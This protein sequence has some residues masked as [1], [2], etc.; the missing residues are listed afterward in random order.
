MRCPGRTVIAEEVEMKAISPLQFWAGLLVWPFDGYSDNCRICRE[1]ADSG[2]VAR[3]R[4]GFCAGLRRRKTASVSGKG[5]DLLGQ[6]F[7][8]RFGENIHVGIFGQLLF[9]IGLI[10]DA[11]ML[12]DFFQHL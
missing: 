6:L 4:R 2:K 11:E 10:I 8:E 12:A 5:P 3:D 7:V 1:C 9:F